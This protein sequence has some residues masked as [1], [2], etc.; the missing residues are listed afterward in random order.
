M[1]WGF[2]SVEK[3]RKKFQKEVTALTKEFNPGLS[4]EIHLIKLDLWKHAM[5][6]FT[7]KSSKA[8]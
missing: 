5:Y 3:F 6:N 7:R 4:K 8:R 1:L 2:L